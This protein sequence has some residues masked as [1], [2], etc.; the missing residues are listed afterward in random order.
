MEH[1]HQQSKGRKFRTRANQKNYEAIQIQEGLF[2]SIV[3]RVNVT[4]G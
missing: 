1:Y 4:K 2:D 3:M